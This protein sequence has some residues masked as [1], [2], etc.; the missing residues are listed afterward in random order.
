MG[1]LGMAG[2][3][4]GGASTGGE[5]G[6]CETPDYPDTA[7]V[8]AREDTEEWGENDFDSVTIEDVDCTLVVSA[9][10]PHE[11][12]WEDADPSEANMEGTKFELEFPYAENADLTGKQVNLTIKLADDGRAD[13]A[14]NGGYDVYLG[15]TE[16]EDG[17]Y[18]ESVTPYEEGM[19]NTPGFSGELYNADEEIMLSWVVPSDD[20][21]FDPTDVYKIFVRVSNK[22]WGD[23]T[24]PVFAYDTAIFEISSLT[25]TDAE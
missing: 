15:V 5:A 24:D 22:F 1:G 12:G 6:T 13:D 10:W 3:L 11:E 20:T 9:E 18:T 17:G 7:Q 19:T 8:I 4:T 23:G 25:V 16:G 2:A 14:E 21:E